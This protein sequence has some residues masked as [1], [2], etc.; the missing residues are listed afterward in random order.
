[1]QLVDL[2]VSHLRLAKLL[3]VGVAQ[4]LA[5]CMVK[6]LQRKTS[7]LPISSGCRACLSGSASF[8]I[9]RDYNISITVGKNGN[10]VSLPAK[11]KA[12][13]FHQCSESYIQGQVFEL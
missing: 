7:F 13:S 9:V 8:I 3:H 5:A 6:V 2:L 10:A 12:K 1:M 11:I 4:L